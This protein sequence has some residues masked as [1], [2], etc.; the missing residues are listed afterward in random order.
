MGIF[1]RNV[2]P[3]LS[4]PIADKRTG[5]L[6]NPWIDYYTY[7]Q[8]TVDSGAKRAA[9]VALSGQQASIGATDFSGGNL[10]EGLYKLSC[11]LYTQVAGAA[12]TL[13]LTFGWTTGSQARTSNKYTLDATSAAAMVA[14]PPLFIRIDGGSPVTYTT[15]NGS[16]APFTY[17]LD[18]L[19][20]AVQL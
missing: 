12:G 18:I 20:E 14:E 10:P 11:Y 2:P 9:S 13:D 16:A 5:L 7:L 8:Q 4:D 6:T 17:G 3:P 15:T 1:V 19:L